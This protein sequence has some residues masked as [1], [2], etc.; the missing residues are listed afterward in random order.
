MLVLG[1]VCNWLVVPVAQSWFAKPE[2]L[3]KLQAQGG[4]TAAKA[5]SFGIGK[6]GLDARAALFWR[7]S[8]FHYAGAFGSLWRTRC[9]FL[10]ER[11]IAV[12]VNSCGAHLDWPG[13]GSFH[14]RGGRRLCAGSDDP[15]GPLHF[16]NLL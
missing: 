4:T 10:V 6:G 2:E 3:V 7:L 15:S 14:A 11:L 9:E 13:A 5:G 12:D 1:F 8:A 16:E